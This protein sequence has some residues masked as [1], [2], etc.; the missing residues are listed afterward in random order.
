MIKKKL[1]DFF[2]KQRLKEEHDNSAGFQS[3]M[4]MGFS[5]KEIRKVYEKRLYKG[6]KKTTLICL[7]FVLNNMEFPFD[8]FFFYVF[9]I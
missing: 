6:K 8:F 2:L 3:V 7:Q 9:M 5:E 4:E 1:S